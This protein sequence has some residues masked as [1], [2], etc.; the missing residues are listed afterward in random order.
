MKNLINLLLL[1]S[2]AFI[3]LLKAQT[4]QSFTSAGTQ[5]QYVPV[6]FSFNNKPFSISRPVIH[7]NRDWLAYG[8]ATINGVGFGWGSGNTMIKLENYTYGMKNSDHT[9]GVY[10][11][12]GK[13]L[14]EW[15][16]SGIIVYLRGGTT[17]YTDGVVQRNDA[18][19]TATVGNQL[20]LSAVPITE[21]DFNI[22]PGIYVADWEINANT[23]NLNTNKGLDINGIIK[24]G[25]H[26]ANLDPALN[27]NKLNALKNTGKLAI[28]WNL[29]GGKGETDLIS[30]R[31]E[32]GSGG[33]HFYD[34]SN[35][36]ERKQLLVLNSN[37]N[38]L[39]DGKL[40][41]REIKVTTTPTADFVFEDSYQLPN[42]E[43]VEKHIKEKKHLPE[44]ASAAEMQK[45]GVNIGDFQIKLLQKIEE[46][47]L[48]SIEQNKLNK[49]QSELLHQQIQINKILEQRLQNL[50]NN[51]QKN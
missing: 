7:D 29:S 4:V 51:N 10:S 25:G 1:T 45:E 8:I 24:T 38:A 21:P 26:A 44:I 20:S 28:G 47:T 42:L 18:T 9:G 14:S 13:V 48:Y 30:N 6:V 37:G 23:Q 50:E 40:E 34:Y 12:M 19:Y 2:V 35:T 17:Y 27:P 41:A 5:D 11:Y 31:G 39:L 3:S 49:E 32:G 46:L 16:G 33:F 36:G 15:T 22:P 43:S